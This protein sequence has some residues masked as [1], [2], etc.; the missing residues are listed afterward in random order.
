MRL[1]ALARRG[2]GVRTVVGREAVND[3]DVLP[4]R[5]LILLCHQFRPDLSSRVANA[6]QVLIS[7][8]QVVGRDLARYLRPDQRRVREE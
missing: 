1:P 3:V 4:E 2:H 7:E 5:F 6:G 8:E